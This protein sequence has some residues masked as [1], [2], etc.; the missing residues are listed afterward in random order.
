M[1]QSHDVTES[2]VRTVAEHENV[3]PDDLPPLEE[4]IDFETLRQLEDAESRLTKRLEFMYLFY[5]VTVKPDGEV[6]VVP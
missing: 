5:Q 4:K 3:S 2:I 6:T 1:A